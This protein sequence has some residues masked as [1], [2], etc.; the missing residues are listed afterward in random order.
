MRV[1]LL[2]AA[3]SG[4]ADVAVQLM[5]VVALV[6]VSVAVPLSAPPPGGD[7]GSAV[8]PDGAQQAVRIEGVV[9]AGA[10]VHVEGKPHRLAAL[11]DGLAHLGL[12]LGR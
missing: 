2:P 12:L 3:E 9:G 10:L 11:A 7:A 5:L 4:M 1:P 8:G 6:P